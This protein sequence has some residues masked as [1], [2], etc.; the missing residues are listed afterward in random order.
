MI[1]GIDISPPVFEATGP[2]SIR[3][4]HKKC[5]RWRSNLV[6]CSSVPILYIYLILTLKLQAAIFCPSVKKSHDTTDGIPKL[7]K[8]PRSMPQG[9]A[10][11]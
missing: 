3:F 1:L 11:N 8:A 2:E 9:N 7:A 4:H 10:S 6:G 5:S